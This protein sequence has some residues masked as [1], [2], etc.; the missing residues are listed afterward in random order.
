MLQDMLSDSWAPDFN[1]RPDFSLLLGAL[2]DILNAG[3]AN[4]TASADGGCCT[5]S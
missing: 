5:V 2:E 4:Q 1:V 3:P